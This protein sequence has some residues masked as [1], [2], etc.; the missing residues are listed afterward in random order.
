MDGKS[1]LAAGFIFAGVGLI[2]TQT[3]L[4]HAAIPLVIGGLSGITPDL[5]HQNGIL[6]KRV[7]VITH[8]VTSLAILFSAMYFSYK[9][10]LFEIS[11]E[12]NLFLLAGVTTF[13][14]IILFLISRLKPKK[15]LLISGIILIVSGNVISSIAL[16]LIGVYFICA[17]QLKHRGLTHSLYFLLFWSCICFYIEKELNYSMIWLTGTLGYFSHLITDHWFSKRKIKWLKTN[18]VMHIVKKIK[19]NIT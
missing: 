14:L 9:I 3:P 19:K 13:V 7:T 6:I 16:I 4:Q 5:D 17:S 2:V 8:W 10:H 15:I 12:G 11:N 1:H 18:E